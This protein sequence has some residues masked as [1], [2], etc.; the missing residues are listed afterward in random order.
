MPRTFS[1]DAALP[2]SQRQHKSGKFAGVL[3]IRR[4]PGPLKAQFKAHCARRDT[5]MTSRIIQLMQADLRKA[6]RPA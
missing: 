1:E 3:F 4:L 6:N 2:R 5:S